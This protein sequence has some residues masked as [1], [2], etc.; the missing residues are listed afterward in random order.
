M[1]YLRAG[2][3]GPG[4]ALPALAQARPHRR[5]RD[6]VQPD[7]AAQ[8]RADAP[9]PLSAARAP[10]RVRADGRVRHAG[11][12]Q[13]RLLALSPTCSPSSASGSTP[14]PSTRSAAP[15]R[16]RFPAPSGGR[17]RAA[18]RCWP[19]TAITISSAAARPGSATG[20]SS[21]G[22]CR[23]G[24]S[25]SRATRIYPFDFL[26]CEFDAS[27][28]RRQRPAG[29]SDAGIREA[30]EQRGPPVSNPVRHH[31]RVRQAAPQ[32][33][34]QGHRQ[35]ARRLDRPLDR[36]AGLERL[37]DGR[38]PRRPRNPRH[39]PRAIEAWLRQPRRAAMG[40]R[41]ALPRPTRT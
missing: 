39:R 8:R 16:N 37:R 27:G 18:K 29:S 7:A 2:Q 13:R 1:R 25:S 5:R 38:Q 35:A 14:P 26:Y 9:Q 22:C 21:I 19:G 10:R 23:A 20:I 28:A 17:A 34:R 30:L 33:S 31:D 40:R 15:G 36:R 6:A 11:R 24:S 41:R 32:A 4:R 12:R 3:R